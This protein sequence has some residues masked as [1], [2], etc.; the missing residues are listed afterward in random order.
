MVYVWRSE[1]RWRHAWR[2]AWRNDVAWYH[3]TVFF[4]PHRDEV[5]VVS[6]VLV[7]MVDS[8]PSAVS[9][10]VVA[11]HLQMCFQKLELTSK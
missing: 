8:G 2:N 6:D 9:L 4:L 10:N 1:W 5:G 7:G 11:R 3:D